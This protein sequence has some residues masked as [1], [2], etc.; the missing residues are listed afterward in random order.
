MRIQKPKIYKHR[1]G[2]LEIVYY[3]RVELYTKVESHTITKKS[4]EAEGST[5]E[6]DNMQLNFDDDYYKS[7]GFQRVRC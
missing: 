7:N 4:V 6:Y 3:D 2:T 1:N 5:L